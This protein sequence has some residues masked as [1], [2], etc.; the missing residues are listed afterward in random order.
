M[1]KILLALMA[2]IG[3]SY[4]HAQTTVSNPFPKTVSVT[5][6]AEMEIVPDEIYVNIELQEYQKKGESKRD[7]ASIRNQFL[8]ACTAAGIPDSLISIVS[9]AGNTNYY[10]IRKKQKTTDLM[11]GI[12]Y[13]IKFS[14]PKLID[15]LISKLD[16][17][18]TKNF[19]IAKLS[20]SR[21][22]QIRRELKVKAVQAAKEKAGYLAEAVG[23]KVG[24][25]VSIN[26]TSDWEAQPFSQYN[27]M[28]NQMMAGAPETAAVDF[29]KMKLSFTINAVFALK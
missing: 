11:A 3:F 1:K 28:A 23:E 2:I 10:T 18:A 9:Y 26:E 13:Q 12:T 20:H 21:L 6:T 7:I 14:N 25:A 17:D 29:K 16:D 27:M 5:G 8:Q 4:T 15:E 22:T 24:E 19:Q